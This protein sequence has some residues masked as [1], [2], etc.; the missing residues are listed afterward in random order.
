MEKFP[1]NIEVTKIL[2]SGNSKFGNIVVGSYTPAPTGA[3]GTTTTTT[4]PQNQATT[5]N[6]VNPVGQPTFIPPATSTAGS[7]GTPATTIETIYSNIK[8]HLPRAFIDVIHVDWAFISGL[9]SPCFCSITE[10]EQNGITLDGIPYWKY[11]HASGTIRN[12]ASDILPVKRGFPRTFNTL[13]VSLM[14]S[15][16]FLIKQT[17]TNWSIELIVFSLPQ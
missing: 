2:L 11:L 6:T 1:E 8:F 5:G 17:D 10:L 7:S 4:V 12:P 9:V 3:T 15:S 14:D 13:T 16:G